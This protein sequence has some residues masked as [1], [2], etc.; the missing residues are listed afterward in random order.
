MRT[1]VTFDPDVA[2]QTSQLREG[3]DRSF[4][5]VVND[6]LRLGLASRD[7]SAPPR[8]GPFTRSVSLGKPLL[9]DVDDI[10]EVL[11]LI[12]GEDHR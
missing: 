9:P 6:L 8:A 1:T 7:A 12:E 11:A 3:G 10:S 4:K 5:Q 2:A